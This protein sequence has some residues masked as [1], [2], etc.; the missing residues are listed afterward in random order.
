MLTTVQPYVF[1]LLQRAFRPC[2]VVE[3]ALG[4]VVQHQQPQRGAPG[5]PKYI[6][7]SSSP[8][9]LPAARIGR[10]PIRLHIRTG[11]SGPSSK[12]SSAGSIE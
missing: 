11:F 6:S 4:V 5:L 2:G 9:E 12:T 8:L 3:F 10:R 7:I 1:A